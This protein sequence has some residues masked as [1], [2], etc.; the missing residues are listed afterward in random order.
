MLGFRLSSLPKYRSEHMV[1]P[2]DAGTLAA[3]VGDSLSSNP[4]PDDSDDHEAWAEGWHYHK[5]SDED[6]EPLDDA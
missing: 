3:A 1:N 4:C 6:G 5:N 2:I